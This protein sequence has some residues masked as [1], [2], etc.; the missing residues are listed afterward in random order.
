[1]IAAPVRRRVANGLRRAQEEPATGISTPKRRAHKNCARWSLLHVDKK[2]DVF[3]RPLFCK[4]WACGYCRPRLSAMWV[5]R[6]VYAY[7]QGW[8]P[9]TFVTLTIDPAELRRLNTSEKWEGIENCYLLQQRWLAQKLKVL[10]T[11]VRRELKRRGLEDKSPTYV[12]VL[13][14][15]RSVDYR[16]RRNGRLHVH[17]LV[18]CP[19]PTGGVKPDT[20]GAT[21]AKAKDESWWDKAGDWWR[22]AAEEIGLGR[23]QSCTLRNVHPYTDS[24][25]GEARLPDVVSYLVKYCAK[26]K[27]D[28]YAHKLRVVAT[29]RNFPR[30]AFE[31]EGFSRACGL[32]AAE[33]YE[34]CRAVGNRVSDPGEGTE[35]CVGLAGDRLP[36]VVLRSAWHW[37]SGAKPG[38]IDLA[39]DY[40]ASDGRSVGTLA[41]SRRVGET[42]RIGRVG[43]WLRCAVVAPSASA[44][45][46][47]TAGFEKWSLGFASIRFERFAKREVRYDS[48]WMFRAA[49]FFC[50]VSP[51][52]L[53]VLGRGSLSVGMSD[54]LLRP[55]KEAMGKNRGPALVGFLSAA[56]RKFS[57]SSEKL[58]MLRSLLDVRAA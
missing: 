11:K 9:N 53:V 6:C 12:R 19:L 31:P 42:A 34:I 7:E 13:E 24:V 22:Q 20:R 18:D 26:A 17:V 4:S 1:M 51:C 36:A 16:G 56:R 25:T 33:V 49:S 47:K 52:S 5:K 45:Y 15:Q 21:R 3:A 50:E 44:A 35:L 54:R 2:G 48:S 38:S 41:E 32:H 55:F 14:A 10:W 39:G 58:A 27:K 46:T 37:R 43:F 23:T 8:L 29:S 28:T 57:V 40:R 30:E